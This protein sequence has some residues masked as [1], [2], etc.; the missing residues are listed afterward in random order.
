MREATEMNATT[1]VF[2]KQPAQWWCDY[3][4]LTKPRIT[5]FCLLMTLGGAAMAP[6]QIVLRTL[7]FALFG[8]ALSVGS[9]NALNMYIERNTDKLMKRTASRPLP[10]G[11]MNEMGALIFAIAL[12][13]GSAVVLGVWVNQATCL[14]SL[15]ALLSYAFVYTP[16]KRMTPHALLVGAIPGAMPP[17]L[18]WTA[19]TG[20]VTAPGLVLF[21]IL[22]IWQI[23]HFI[24]IAV[25]HKEDYKKAGIKTWPG[26]RGGRSATFQALIYS[27]LLIPISLMLNWLGIASPVYGIISVLLGVWMVVLSARGFNPVKHAGWA[28]KLFV[29]S[30][31]Y[32][33]VLT[34]TLAVDLLFIR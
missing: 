23:P 25:N 10:S 26:E 4:E 20:E 18:G 12:G 5:L 8:T 3:L 22:L 9:A 32:L 6:E 29:A 17:L 27:L 34:L 24:A 11:R 13:L 31:V 7:L 14:L 19:V 16:L 30:L 28:K 15:F 21:A 33:P 2:S 1:E